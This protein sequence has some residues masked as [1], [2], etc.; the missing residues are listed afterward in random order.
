MT[1]QAQAVDSEAI[2]VTDEYSAA[3]ALE[4]RWD[5]QEETPEPKD[6]EALE[7]VAETEEVSDES[8]EVEETETEE[9]DEL[10]E[11]D[12]QEPEAED[13]E[14]LHYENVDQL[15]EATGMTKDEFLE[16]IKITRKIDGVEEEVTLAELRNGNQRDADY[17]RKTSAHADNVRAFEAEVGQAKENLTKQF[18]EA[19]QM[20][21]ILEE[22]LTA[23]FQGVD[24][25]ALEQQDREEWLVQ[26]QKFGERH[27]QIQEL[28]TKAQEKLAEQ[29]AGL[30]AKQQE[31]ENKLREEHGRRL[32]EVIPEWQDTEVWK[33]DDKQLR[34]FLAGYDITDAEINTFYD[35]RLIKLARDAMKNQGKSEKV[36]TVKKKVKK[37]PKMIK[38][39]A[40]T[41][42]VA[43][44]RKQSSDKLKQF[45]KKDKHTNEDVA[46]LLLDRMK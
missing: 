42:K 8:E 37:L 13:G 33:A 43:V 22:Q 24:W 32:L 30:T 12:E 38:P 31:A 17:R 19:A 7:E 40:Q 29:Q 14:I 20:T 44:K 11:S 46:A 35:S 27:Q 34:S 1:D 4:A 16:S 21:A 28:K 5:A 10:D 2:E 25:N 3:K 15:A 26:R 9:T 18:Q 41:D 23:E 36:E 39:G 45:R 6:D